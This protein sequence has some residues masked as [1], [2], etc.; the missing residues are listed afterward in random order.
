ML[1][2]SDTHSLVSYRTILYVS[3]NKLVR[4]DAI[5]WN[6]SNL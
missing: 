4:V 1:K 6:S 3:S 5:C 2:A